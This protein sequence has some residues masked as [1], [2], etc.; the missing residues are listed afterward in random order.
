MLFRSALFGPDSRRS[1]SQKIL[2]N[3]VLT[4]NGEKREY[5]QHFE[6]SRHLI[7]SDEWFKDTY[8][9]ELDEICDFADHVAKKE[10]VPQIVREFDSHL[11]DRPEG[12]RRSDD[13]GDIL[14][15]K[16]NRLDPRK[17]WWK[18]YHDFVKTLNRLLPEY[19]KNED[20]RELVHK[21]E[22]ISYTC[23]RL[24]RYDSD[25]D[26]ITLY[27]YPILK[28]AYKMGVCFTCVMQSVCDH[29]LFHYYHFHFM[30]ASTGTS[31]AW[32]PGDDDD[33]HIVNSIKEG[34][35]DYFAYTRAETRYLYLR[36]ENSEGWKKIM[37]FYERKW[38][39]HDSPLFPYAA[40]D[41]FRQ[42]ENNSGRF[43]ANKR[44][45]RESEF[46][47]LTW[48]DPK[49]PAF[50]ALL[51]SLKDES[52]NHWKNAW[53]A[54]LH[55]DEENKKMNP[56][57]GKTIHGRMLNFTFELCHI[58]PGETV[59]YIE[60]PT[61]SAVVCDARHVMYKNKKYT[62][63]GLARALHNNAPDSFRG[64]TF[65]T[66]KGVLLSDLRKRFE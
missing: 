41:V 1:E 3:G 26:R 65:F 29:E 63:S 56:P 14:R 44:K 40:A 49:A 35:A 62:L 53:E 15:S 61:I 46:L 66:Y 54:M 60:D 22:N 47:H 34:L 13:A 57:A 2:G 32:Y 28:W 25:M 48:T 18:K 21:A 9:Y 31:N 4:I 64:P 16:K 58:Q 12:L 51:E 23:D 11:H 20:Y 36:D 59:E 39:G 8:G 55:I 10:D 37:K 19:E 24:G 30:K 50:Q 33:S 17:N 27:L 45:L 6:T 5:L 52:Q 7:A 42:E 43:P 38:S